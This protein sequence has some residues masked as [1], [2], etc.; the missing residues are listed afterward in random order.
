MLLFDRL[1][2][3][4]SSCLTQRDDVKIDLPFI[5]ISFIFAFSFSRIRKY[6]ISSLT[7]TEIGLFVCIIS[8]VGESQICAKG[9]TGRITYRGV[10]LHFY[11]YG[12]CFVPEQNIQNICKEIKLLC[13]LPYEC[14]L[15]LNSC[16]IQISYECNAFFY[17]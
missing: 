13:F 7:E 2:F 14:E 9:M 8:N 10:S 4:I 12:F 11:G 6:S 3:S 1:Y 16:N 5:I 15:V 17:I